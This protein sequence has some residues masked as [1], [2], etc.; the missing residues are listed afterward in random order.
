MMK[1]LQG[2]LMLF[3]L[4]LVLIVVGYFFGMV[5]AIIPGINAF[6]TG[7][8][9]LT[10]DMLPTIFAWLTLLGVIGYAFLIAGVKGD[11][12]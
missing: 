4:A 8:P 9:F 1:F 10:P 12:K 7:V 5:F 2:L 6:L 3:V 11:E